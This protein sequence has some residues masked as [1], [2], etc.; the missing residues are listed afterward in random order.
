MLE[1]I[2]MALVLTS[3]RDWD[4]EGD[5]PRV[6]PSVCS[7]FTVGDGGVWGRPVGVTVGKDGSLFV[8]DDGTN[9]IWR[10]SYVKK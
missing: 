8:S 6:P 3:L 10:V 2:K 7:G 5:Y 4:V 9:S 1:T